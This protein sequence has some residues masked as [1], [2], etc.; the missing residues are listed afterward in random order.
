MQQELNN[1]STEISMTLKAYH[2]VSFLFIFLPLLSLIWFYAVSVGLILSTCLFV[3]QLQ[4]T[5]ISV[6]HL[7]KLLSK[8]TQ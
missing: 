3:Y 7:A 6:Y 1:I 8:C 2:V 4:L 5:A